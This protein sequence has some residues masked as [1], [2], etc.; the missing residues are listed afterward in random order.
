MS[1]NS[2]SIDEMLNRVNQM[3]PE[4]Q[5]AVV[6][7][8]PDRV[9]TPNAGP[10]TEAYYCEADE[11]FYGGSAGGGKS[12]LMI[13][14]SLTQHTKSLVL[15][16][17]NKEAIK[18]YDRYETIVGNDIGLN[19]S[20]GIWKFP[21]GSPLSGKVI[22][23]GGCQLESDKQKRKGIDHDLKAL[24]EIGDFS[25]TQYEFII[26]WNR[27]S[28]PGQ[29][30]RVLATGNPP[31]NPEGYWV[32]DRWGAW[33]DP[34]HPNPA[35]NG[36]LRWYTTVD[37]KEKEVDGPG[38]HLINGEEVIA[39][40]RTFIR[41]RLE[42]NPDLKSTN[43]DAV[44]A[45]L[46]ERERLAYREGRFDLSIQDELNQAIPTRWVDA[47][48]ERWEIKPESHI[49]MCAIG[50][51]MSGGGKDPMILAPRF[52]GWYSE[53]T[54]IPAKD[55]PE[56]KLG[57]TAAGHIVMLRRD[58]AVIVIDLGGGYGSGTHEHL[59][60]NEIEVYGYKGSEK[61][62][63]RSTESNLPFFNVR[64]AAIWQFREALDPDQPGGSPIALP[65]DPELKADLT[66][67]TYVIKNNIIKIEPKIEVCTRIGRS[68]DKGDAVVMGWF[69]G[70]RESTAAL[71]WID[72]KIQ[73]RMRGQRPK[74]II[75]RHHARRR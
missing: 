39:R 65:Y 71:D 47:A 22:D 60:A 15:R 48:M 17:T 40:S 73:K 51:D 8:L 1:A 69:V 10:Q 53:L 41:A 19:R 11:L 34:K 63:R 49:P 46:P 72:R 35:K 66:A 70:P 12:D 28:I 55:L 30:C 14:L 24:D 57:S 27:S 38:P 31:T 61:T 20:V 43:Y 67:P 37:G 68:T 21:N 13:G 9:W 2:I 52:D 36:E 26:A 7:D 29:R 75:G 62:T 3:T 42:D 59:A 18:L 6:K 44:L 54:V 56:D 74:V 33:L 23:I 64:S 32:I 45:A 25:R 4:Q 50:A 16:R 5:K 58:N